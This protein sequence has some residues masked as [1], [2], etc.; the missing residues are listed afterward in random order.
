MSQSKSPPLPSPQQQPQEHIHSTSFLLTTLTILTCI[1]ILLIPSYHSTD[2]DVHRNW[3]ALTR[4]LPLSEWYFDSQDGRTVHTLD[5]P[6]LFAF[7]EAAMSRSGVTTWLMTRGYLDE[8]CLERLPD[9]DNEVSESCVLFQRGSVILSDVVLIAGGYLASRVVGTA[10]SG[11]GGGGNVKSLVI[12]VL[13]VANPGLLLLDH[14]HFQYNG[15]LL[16]LLLFSIG[17]IHKCELEQSTAGRAG[18]FGS[19][20]IGAI[21]YAALVTMKHLYLPLAPIYFVYLLRLCCF[22]RRNANESSSSSPPPPPTESFSITAFLKLA[23]VTLTTLVLPFLPFMRQSDPTAQLTQMLRRLF[24]FARG[25]CHDYWAANV[26]ALYLF[27]DK[28]VQF[29]GRKLRLPPFATSLPDVPPK[30]TAVLL[31][32]ALVP[33]MCAAWTAARQVRRYGGSVSSSKLIVSKAS[34]FVHAVVYSS[35]SGFMLAYHAH[36]KAIMTAIIP[37]TLLSTTS[38]QHA[39]LYIRTCAIG[40]FGLFPLLFRPIELTFKVSSYVVHLCLSVFLLEYVFQDGDD[41]TTAKQF[42]D[43]ETE[44][45][46]SRNESTGLLTIWDKIGLGILALLLVFAEV[47]HPLYFQPRQKLEFL[48]L[49]MISVTCAI[50]LVFCWVHS[51]VLMFRCLSL[52]DEKKEKVL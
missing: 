33:A 48:P 40:H 38:R 8:R 17:F 9:D 43:S 1:K 16:G 12:M 22:E 47:I 6:P 19:H 7:F 34:F 25:L 20:M 51:G 46:G 49:M 30:V 21:F 52:P 3:L 28:C 27:C 44:S 11:G 14:V 4:T 39:Q 23:F 35:F 18:M 41:G 37:L 24:P 50:A 45:N 26:W 5:Y 15:M 13:I 42:D 31:L 2:F 10:N 32:L 36:E 29:V